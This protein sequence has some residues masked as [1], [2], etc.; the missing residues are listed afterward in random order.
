MSEHMIDLDDG[1]WQA[2]ETIALYYAGRRRRLLEDADRYHPSDSRRADLVR[3]AQEAEEQCI[4][5]SAL[6][7]E[8]WIGSADYQEW[9]EL[10]LEKGKVSQN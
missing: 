6:A 9:H 8:R 2:A 5:W 10:E 1:R 7:Y 4:Q 3:Q